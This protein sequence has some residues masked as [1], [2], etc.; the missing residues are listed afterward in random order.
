MSLRD[1]AN[2][3]GGTHSTI[4]RKLDNDDPQ[5]IVEIAK[6]FGA[7]PVGVLISIE[8]LNPRDVRNY[9]AVSNLE[10]YDDLE[11]AEEIVRR[12]R[13]RED[14]EALHGNIF[15]LSDYQSVPADT[16][17]DYVAKRGT[18]EPEEGDDDYGDGA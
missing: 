9:A 8:F 7:N 2:A 14:H 1:L 17:L 3:I 15:E 6:H 5:M 4:G 10:N 12:L 13:E 11:L 16:H 18:P